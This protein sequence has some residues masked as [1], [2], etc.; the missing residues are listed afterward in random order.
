MVK[1]PE[2]SGPCASD[3]GKLWGCEKHWENW[4]AEV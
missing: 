1:E 2:E 4:E 3:R